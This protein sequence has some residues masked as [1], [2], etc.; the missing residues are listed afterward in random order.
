MGINSLQIDQCLLCFLLPTTVVNLTMPVL[1]W[2][3]LKTWHVGSVSCR[4][5]FIHRNFFSNGGGVWCIRRGDI[6][7][8]L[9]EVADIFLLYK[10]QNTKLAALLLHWPYFDMLTFTCTINRCL[11]FNAVHLDVLFNS[12]GIRIIQFN[13][14]FLLLKFTYTRGY[15]F[16]LREAI[17]RPLP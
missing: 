3:F 5:V 1:Y 16:Q 12:Q 8:Q 13:T 14:S 17:I 4:Y 15:M 7:Y 11:Q 6:R 10:Y 2:V 9:G